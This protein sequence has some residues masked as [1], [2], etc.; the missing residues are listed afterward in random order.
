MYVSNPQNA[1]IS[2]LTFYGDQRLISRQQIYRVDGD[3]VESL[4][5][6]YIIDIYTN[7]M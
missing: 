3:I 4:N 2:D 5:N 1:D 7:I 6:G